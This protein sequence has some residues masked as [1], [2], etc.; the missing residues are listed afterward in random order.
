[1][2][3]NEAIKIVKN[4]QPTNNQILDEALEFLIPELKESED[5]K[6]RKT[7]IEYFNAYP[8]DYYGELK[9]SSIIGWLEKQGEQNLNT[10]IPKFKE[11]ETIIH[12]DL[13]G[14]YIHNPHKIIQVDVLENKYLL[15]DGLTMHF[16]E[17]D[18]YELVEQ[19][20]TD[21][22]E[23]KFKSGDWV[24]DVLYDEAM[25]VLFLED[26][27]Y[28]LENGIW[29]PYA[30]AKERVHLWTLKDAKDGDVLIS[31][32]G[33]PFIYNGNLDSVHIGSYCGITTE[34]RFSVAT[35]KCCWT[36]NVDI[37]PA[38]RGERD[39]LF[40]KM[41]KAGYEWDA[42]KKKLWKRVIDEGKAEMDYCFTKM[43]NGEKVSSAWTEDDEKN[44][45][46]LCEYLKEYGNPFYGAE[47]SAIDW[48]NSLKERV[49]P[50]PKQEWS[51]EDERIHNA[52]I[53]A[54]QYII[55]NFENSTK[56]YE[57]AIDWLNSLKERVQPKPNQEWSEDDENGLGDALWAIKQ[58]RTIAK[59]ENDMGNL[60]YAENWLK[61]IKDRVQPQPK[62]EW[63]EED[64]RLCGCLIEE[65]EEALDNVR[66]DKY[67]HSEIISDLK[68]MYHER[69]DW[70]KSLKE[71]MKGE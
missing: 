25:K 53:R 63:S 44:L 37:Q 60:W 15:E 21:N 2:D 9:T 69:I 8:K 51:E 41:K 70:L 27:G 45:E 38:T 61:S 30:D 3:R 11:G 5:E 26:D 47:E 58:A 71:R 68:D 16:S 29:I 49:Q 57:D 23:P 59:D 6:I 36:E 13:G 10:T 50:K 67:G 28:E 1:M 39:F 54:C 48:L 52:S 62:Q 55:D 66:N 19:K 4:N 12:K 64:E 32:Y 65:Q 42:D 20:H 18:D 33:K 17:Q 31:K 43:M 7:L 46:W 56:D 34:G 22:L 35:E 14:D 24:V 40:S